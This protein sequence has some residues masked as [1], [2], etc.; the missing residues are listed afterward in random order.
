[1]H[2]IK[3][4]TQFVE[5]A[6]SVRYQFSEGCR[7][8]I[9]RPSC[10]VIFGASGDLSRRKIFPAL[11]RLSKRELFPEHFFVVGTARTEMSDHG[12]RQLLRESLQKA[13]PDD[14]DDEFWRRFSTRLYY[15]VVDYGNAESY[16]NLLAKLVPLEQEHRTHQNRVLYLSVPPTVYEEIILNLG[17]A[18]LSEEGPG[19]THIVVEKPFGR[20][21][22]SANH[23][24]G[25]LRRFFD[26]HQ[27]YRMDHYLAK[28]T[29][30]N[31]LM[32]R[33]ANSIF[34]PLWNRRYIDHIQITVSETLGV[35]HR[36]G[37]Y[38]KAGI[39]RDMFQNHIFQLLAVT[40]MEPPAAFDAERVRDEK[41][42]VFRSIRPFPLDSIASW[43]VVGQYA[44]GMIGDRRVPAYG[45]EPGVTPGSRTPTYAAMKVMIDNWRWNGVPFY[46]RSG[47]RLSSQKAEISIHYRP[48]PHLM[49]AKTI[50]EP[51]DPNTL[52]L[53]VQPDEGI[54]LVFQAKIPGSKVCMMPVVM[55]FSYQRGFA[56]EAY[57]RVLLD[58]MQ[59][60]QMLFVREDGVVETWALLT[61]VLRELE[62][63]ADAVPLK[64]YAAGSS[65]PA[66]ASLMMEREG[67]AWRQL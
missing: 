1:M 28:E 38:E 29:V 11:Y 15:S 31:I 48:V 9:P 32:F 65:G 30:Q 22:E 34:E 26:E 47:K 27:I 20:D 3:T 49:F 6:G 21:L 5:V 33:F 42:K 52:V 36:A 8:E 64:S 24:N 58:C 63:G 66:E 61:P 45:D 12:F 4:D 14:F 57:E 2:Q 62:S 56:L 10:L 46:L 37:Y 44:E 59:G 19:F 53:R 16:R 41:A 51:I 18:G 54:N 25:V 39:I 13:L 43:L 60:D 17:T 50:K 35:E 40:A 67:R 23:L 7:L 55:D